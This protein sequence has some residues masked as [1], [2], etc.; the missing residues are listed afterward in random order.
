[1]QF[2]YYWPAKNQIQKHSSMGLVVLSN[3]DENEVFYCFCCYASE[4]GG[5][6]PTIDLHQRVF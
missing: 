3:V 6:E 2:V 5:C 1:V 4:S